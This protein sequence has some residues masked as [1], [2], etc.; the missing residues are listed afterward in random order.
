MIRA[1]SVNSTARDTNKNGET[2][3]SESSAGF[4]RVFSRSAVDDPLNHTKPHFKSVSFAHFRGSFYFESGNLS[5]Q[6]NTKP[7]IVLPAIDHL[8][9][10]VIS[11]SSV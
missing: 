4:V 1:F 3:T 11:R 8:V 10:S 5:I 6:D 9:L 7:E 2:V